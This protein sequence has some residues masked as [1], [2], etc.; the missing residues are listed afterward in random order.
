MQI[1]FSS[2]V[3]ITGLKLGAVADVDCFVHIFARDLTTLSSSRLACL[4]ERCALPTVAV[5]PV[6]VE[7]S[8][9]PFFTSASALIRLLSVPPA[10]ATVTDHV[11]LRGRYR[12]LP[13]GLYG[14]QLSPQD[15]A[16]TVPEFRPAQVH[17]CS[18][19]PPKRMH[20]TQHS[21]CAGRRSRATAA[22][23]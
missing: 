17:S 23:L 5:K 3:C 7:V 10:Q 21:E 13:V 2:P 6:R 15:Q 11:V 22:A 19:G 18:V 16:R 12:A 20:P 4:Q 14:W 8:A 9:L 1:T